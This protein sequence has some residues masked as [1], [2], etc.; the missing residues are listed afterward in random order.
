M[1]LW[2][3]PPPGY[4]LI[5][6]TRVVV[7]QYIKIIMTTVYTTIFLLFRSFTKPEF[8]A[9]SNKAWDHSTLVSVWTDYWSEECFFRDM[10]TVSRRRGHYR[11][12]WPLVEEPHRTTNLERS[13]WSTDVCWIS[14]AGFWH[15]KG[16]WNRYNETSMTNTRK[17]VYGQ[18]G[19]WWGFDLRYIN[20]I[21]IDALLSFCQL[22]SYITLIL[23]HS[24]QTCNFTIIFFG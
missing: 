23:T 1:E 14:T 18:K 16:L 11:A 7:D 6:S 8:P 22:P 17:K 19:W 24:F 9:D 20:Y 13:G 12:V 10:C 2:I 5:H 4:I 21:C 15:W 3:P